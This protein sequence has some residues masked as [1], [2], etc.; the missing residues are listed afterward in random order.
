MIESKFSEITGN[1]DKYRDPLKQGLYFQENCSELPFFVFKEGNSFRLEYI[2]MVGF[3][4]PLDSKKLTPMV[5]ESITSS[6]M[7]RLYFIKEKTNLSTP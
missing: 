2:D 7:D 5:A 3:S 6:L 4:E 1:T